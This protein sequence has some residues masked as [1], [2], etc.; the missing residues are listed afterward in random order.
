LECF[1]KEQQECLDFC[2][3]CSC[4]DNHKLKLNLMGQTSPS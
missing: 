1:S 2:L 3:F 4:S